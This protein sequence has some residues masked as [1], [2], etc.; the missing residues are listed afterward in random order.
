MDLD[1]ESSTLADFYLAYRSMLRAAGDAPLGGRL[2]LLS[3]PG[4][5][6]SAAAAAAAAARIAGAACLLLIADERQAKEVVRAGYCDYLVTSLDEA[7]RILKNEV[8]RQA[9]TAVCLLGEPSHSLALCVGRGIQPDLLDL[10]SL[11]SHA[12]GACGELVARGARPIA[13]E[14]SWNVEEQAV[15]W[16]VPHGPLALLALVDALARRAVEEQARGAERLRW[17]TQA[18]ATLGRG[19]Q[20]ERLLPMRPVEVSRFVALAR[21]QASLAEEGGLQVLVDGVEILLQA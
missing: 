17:L 15:A 13:W 14:S 5:R 4:Q 18:P 19:W 1:F 20:R 10:V 7:V 12:D 11:A 21:D 8:R 16:N 3:H 6:R 9:A 2:V